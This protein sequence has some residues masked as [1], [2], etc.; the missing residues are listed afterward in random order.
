MLMVFTS[1][2]F[3]QAHLQHTHRDIGIPIAQQHHYQPKHHLLEIS[4]WLDIIITN[5]RKLAGCIV[6]LWW[7]GRLKT[8]KAPTLMEACHLLMESVG[9]AGERS[10]MILERK[11]FAVLLEIPR[12][13]L[14][15]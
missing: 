11:V 4:P 6:L 7:R 2:S 13:R 9:Q 15:L 8:Q 14:T 12:P 5:A 10:T 3:E 1:R